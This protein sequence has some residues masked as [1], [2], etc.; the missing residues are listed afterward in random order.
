MKSIPHIR[1][2]LRLLREI[3][4]IRLIQYFDE[5]TSLRKGPNGSCLLRIEMMS[6]TP[7]AKS[8]YD[9]RSVADPVEA[10]VSKSE[11]EKGKKRKSM[12]QENIHPG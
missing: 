8:A 5:A 4:K 12:G 11:N 2:V 9:D 7:F 10:A 6:S 1:T 3:V